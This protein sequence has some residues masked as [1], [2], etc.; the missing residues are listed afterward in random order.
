MIQSGLSDERGRLSPDDR[1]EVWLC[2]PEHLDDLRSDWALEPNPLG[3]ILIHLGPLLKMKVAPLGLVIADL[4][5][6]TG[7]AETHAA[8]TLLASCFGETDLGT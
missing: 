4:A 2:D 1:A 7:E 6:W 5:D 3:K 8:N